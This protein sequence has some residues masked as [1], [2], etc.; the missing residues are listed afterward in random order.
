MALDF[1]RRVRLVTGRVQGEPYPFAYGDARF[2]VVDRLP[3]N[4]LAAYVPRN[5][6][7]YL[8][9]EVVRDPLTLTEAL[10]H[11]LTHYEQAKEQ[12][13]GLL[14]RLAD[15]LYALVTPY[16]QRWFER[17]AFGVS[18]RVLRDFLLLQRRLQR[19]RAATSTSDV[20]RGGEPLAAS[21]P[22]YRAQLRGG[23]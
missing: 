16:E 17:E 23:Q 13:P 12:P 15:A 1:L 14:A 7:V 10:S 19:D 4:A 8:S 5:N 2:V 11:E 21:I 22:H 3:D 6:T 20:V 18:D 9:R